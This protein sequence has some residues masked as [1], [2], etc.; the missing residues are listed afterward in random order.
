V[1]IREAVIDKLMKFMKAA[2]STLMKPEICGVMH[3]HSTHSQDGSMTLR[4]LAGWCRKSGLKFLMISEHPEILGRKIID[5]ARMRE[6]VK[7]CNALSDE[8]FIIIPGLEF[9]TD[10]GMHILAYGIR[11]YFEERGTKKSIEKI[12]ELGGLAV[13]A[14]V[15][16]YDEIPFEKLSGI[17]GIEVWNTLYDGWLAPRVGNLRI[18][19]KIK[20]A[21]A[22][23]GSDLHR[24][25]QLGRM[26]VCV[27]A[28]RLDEKEILSALKRGDACFRGRFVSFN[29]DIYI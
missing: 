14:H 11:K 21:K 12:H 26:L 27:K 9:M 10:D 5:R 3:V 1:Q 17:D 16:I 2:A 15:S 18:L 4:Q 25:E 28:K 23:A 7:E 8:N 24:E 20:G 6:I 22:F 19:G 29:P 13:L